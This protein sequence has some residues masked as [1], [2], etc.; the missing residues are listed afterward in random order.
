MSKKLG[1]QTYI[2]VAKYPTQIDS[3]FSTWPLGS[4]VSGSWWGTVA[5]RKHVVE[6]RCSACDSWEA[7]AKDKASFKVMPPVAYILQPGPHLPVHDIKLSIYQ[8]VNPLIMSEPSRSSYLPVI[9]SICWRQVSKTGTFWGGFHVQIIASAIIWLY[10]IWPSLLLG[11]DVA[12]NIF[13]ETGSH[14]VQVD[15]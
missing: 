5:C 15:T 3:S 13:I 6:Q 4:T 12:L 7:G 2:T 9:G 11:I 10:S 1:Y 8:G 14:V